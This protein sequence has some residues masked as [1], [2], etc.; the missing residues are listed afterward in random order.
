V[1]LYTEYV[2]TAFLA[3]F[4]KTFVDGS[5]MVVYH[6]NVQKVKFTLK[7]IMKAHRRS[8]VIAALFLQP[9]R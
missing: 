8:R 1:K 3:Y 5:M 2:F 7:Q 6:R 4:T 9:R